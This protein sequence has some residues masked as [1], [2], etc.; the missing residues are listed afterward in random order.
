MHRT[1]SFKITDVSQAKV[2]NNFK[3]ADK[4]FIETNL[5]QFGSIK[6]VGQIN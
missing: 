5:Q 2:I 4:K 3:N 1:R 6:F